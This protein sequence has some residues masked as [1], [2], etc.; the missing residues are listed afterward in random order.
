[1][2]FSLL[3]DIPPR[4]LGETRVCKH[5]SAV[6]YTVISDFHVLFETCIICFVYVHIIISMYKQIHKI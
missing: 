5:W 3:K 6:V 2:Y 1:M 4:P